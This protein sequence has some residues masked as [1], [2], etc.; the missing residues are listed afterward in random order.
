VIVIPQEQSSFRHLKQKQ[1]PSKQ[2]EYIETAASLVTTELT[3][4]HKY[5]ALLSKICHKMSRCRHFL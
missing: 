1:Y 5:T 2:E 3:N 4:W